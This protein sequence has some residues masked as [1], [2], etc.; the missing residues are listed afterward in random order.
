VRPRGERRREPGA[1]DGPF[2]PAAVGG[3]AR[4]HV[5][6]DHGPSAGIDRVDQR[7][8]QRCGC[9]AHA[10]A[11]Q[12]IDDHI[13]AAE[14]RRDL[15]GVV[16]DARGNTGPTHFGELDGG[17]TV[18]PVRRDDEQHVGPRARAL[19]TPRDDEAVAAVAAAAARERHSEIARPEAALRQRG[20]QRVGRATAGVL[21]EG[22]TG[23]AELGDRPRVH[24]AHR[25]R[26]EDRSHQRPRGSVIACATKSATIA[27]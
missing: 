5:E 13:R 18:Q 1:H 22:G 24:A 19:E 15:G 10:G 27:V 23:D 7:R 6:G 2:R 17:I 20:E 3:Q 11:E 16:D 21:H 14:R 26:G 25:L 9:A 12:R 8:D 4:R